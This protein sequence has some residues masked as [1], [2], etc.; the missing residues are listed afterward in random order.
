M[1]TNP[2]SP[3]ISGPRKRKPSTKASTNGDPQ[4]A[5]KRQ[6]SGN[7]T[8]KSVTTALTKKKKDA[9]RPSKTATV[10]SKATSILARK[11]TQKR[12][13]VESDDDSDDPN[14]SPQT[15]NR[16]LE[17]QAAD[18]SDS[19]DSLDPAQELILVDEDDNEEKVET[20]LEEP[21][22]SAEAE[23][24][25]IS[26]PY[27]TELIASRSER[28]SKEWTSPIYVFY[29]KEPRVDHVKGRRIHVFECAAGKC[30]G[31]NGRDVRRYLDTCDAKSTSSLRRH[32]K[33]C[34][35]S[36]AVE[37]AD[38]TKDLESARL[39]LMKTKLRDGSITAQFEH[40]AK[41]KVTFS[42]RQ[43]TTTEVR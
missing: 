35:G 22:E 20:Y 26:F 40:I 30:R 10:T 41:G 36:E 15:P 34:W 17:A 27:Q 33:K 6:K 8:N 29:R 42:H 16:V 39:V 12:P 4:E 13:I 23:L 14:N 32:A 38:G 1:A 43:H 18:G 7:T 3:D 19:D 9:P 28:L 37:A 11:S 2:T 31:K 5:R 21:E 24:G 25:M